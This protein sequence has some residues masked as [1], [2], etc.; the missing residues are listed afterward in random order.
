M[1][2]VGSEVG[3]RFRPLFFKV[4]LLRDLLS[5]FSSLCIDECG[6]ECYNAKH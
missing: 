6:D 1:L 2:G 4:F 5:R 3:H